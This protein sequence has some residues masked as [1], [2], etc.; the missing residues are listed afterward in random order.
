MN[1]PRYNEIIEELQSAKA[2]P[3]ETEEHVKAENVEK[4]SS[5]HVMLEWVQAQWEPHF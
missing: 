2:E 3:T 4:K 1:S 5:L